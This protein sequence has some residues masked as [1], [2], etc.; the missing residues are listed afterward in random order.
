[1]A[2]LFSDENFPQPV[3]ER[4][5]E[6]G[7]VVMTLQETGKGNLSLSDPEVLALASE[8]QSILLTMNRRHFIQLHK[9]GLAHKGIFVCT[10]DPNFEGLAERIDSALGD[11]TNFDSEL[12]RINRPQ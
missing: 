3:V 6:L 5:Q 8:H 9:E 12:I 2:Y 10:H 11:R 1:V 4:L 7:H